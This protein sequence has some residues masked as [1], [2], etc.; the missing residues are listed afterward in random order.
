[1]MARYKFVD[2]SPRFLPVVLEDHLV[3]GSTRMQYIIW[4]APW[5]EEVEPRREPR[6]TIRWVL[7]ISKRCRNHSRGATAHAPAVGRIKPRVEVR[8]APSTCSRR[9]R[10]WPQTLSVAS[11]PPLST[12]A[13]DALRHRLDPTYASLRARAQHRKVGELQKGRVK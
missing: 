8:S 11:D 5:M 13:T 6:P 12:A 1:M 9:I 10:Q 2:M 7:R 3:P 4:P